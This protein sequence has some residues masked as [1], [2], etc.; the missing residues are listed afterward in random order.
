[1]L[2]VSTGSSKWEANET[3]ARDWLVVQVY[4]A[5]WAGGDLGAVEFVF[6]MRRF[7]R[8]CLSRTAVRDLVVILRATKNPGNLKCLMLVSEACWSHPISSS[9]S[10]SHRHDE[11][12]VTLE[13][14]HP[15]CL[16]PSEYFRRLIFATY[17]GVAAC[18]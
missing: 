2:R 8:C 14:K 6:I 1:M 3:V 11:A 10:R 15:K 7:D 16:G 18:M 5:A 13:G 4:R 17:G 12:T 9:I